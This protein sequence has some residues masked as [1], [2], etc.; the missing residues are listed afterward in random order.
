MSITSRLLWGACKLA[1][2][3][4]GKTAIEVPIVAAEAGYWTI[5]GLGKGAVISKDF[6]KARCQTKQGKLRCPRGHAVPTEGEV[7]LCQVCGFVYTGSVWRCANPECRA[8]TPFCNCPE[9]G[10][11]IRN[12]YRY[13]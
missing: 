11:S 5:Y 4:V 8:I 3:A 2:R 6:I 7:Y 13:G 9:C 1:G 12:P 10:L